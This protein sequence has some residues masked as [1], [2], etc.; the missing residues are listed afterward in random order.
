MRFIALLIVS[1]LVV[2]AGCLRTPAVTSDAGDAGQ[3]GD[4]TVVEDVGPQDASGD[5]CVDD[6]DCPDAPN[7]PASCVDGACATA[8]EDGY[9]DLDG[10]LAS[11][12]TNGCECEK[13]GETDDTCDGVDDDCDGTVDDEA[14][15]VLC[16]LQEGVC[17]GIGTAC[18]DGAYPEC[19]EAF[20]SENVP[21]WVPGSDEGLACDG[22]DNDCDGEVDNVCCAADQEPP[23]AVVGD[24]LWPTITPALPGAPAGAEFLVGYLESLE[25]V[26]LVHVDAEGNTVGDEFVTDLPYDQA[27]QLSAATGGGEYYVLV[28]TTDFEDSTDRVQIGRFSADLTLQDPWP[29]AADHDDIGA[30]SIAVGDSHACV[31]W[32]SGPTADASLDL[33]CYPH[34]S[35]PQAATPGEI[36]A[37]AG[38][39][40]D[41]HVAVAGDRF[42]VAFATE[43]RI[44]TLTYAADGSDAR[45]GPTTN[46]V[47][48]RDVE[49]T[50]VGDQVVVGWLKNDVL[51]AREFA[52]DG[53]PG[54]S[55]TTFAP[56]TDEFAL[57]AN[58][59][60]LVVAA[61]NEAVGYADVDALSPADLG[62]LDELRPLLSG[63]G[64]SGFGTLGMASNGPMTGLVVVIDGSVRFGTISRQ[65]IPICP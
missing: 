6:G 7:A 56:E 61:G 44:N 12:D 31:L 1:M 60:N 30:A 42:A 14:P 48:A 10:D 29:T 34:G 39:R 32:E 40:L 41:S 64:I 28:R 35:P 58:G 43:D 5:E 57:V 36:F 22:L 65:G 37:S 19:D 23:L 27:T 45:G 59:E 24:G 4:V 49:L 50:A 3:A 63:V 16:E 11:D 47:D 25:I 20:L 13:L 9:V 51:Y 26:H 15:E 52:S 2:C 53:T 18:T 8:C 62:L 54:G 46:V 55:A 17:A 38:T 33:S 21:D